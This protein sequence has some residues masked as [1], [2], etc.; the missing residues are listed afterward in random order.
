MHL[1]GTHF[2]RI[3][4]PIWFYK[5]NMMSNM[6]YWESHLCWLFVC[7]GT[8]GCMWFRKQ[9]VFHSLKIPHLF[10][11]FPCR[12]SIQFSSDEA[13]ACRL[14]TNE[15][16]FYDARD[17]SKGILRRLR[18]PGVAG[19]EISKFPGSHVAAFT[20][21]SKVCNSI[22]SDWVSLVFCMNVDR[23]IYIYTNACC[24]TMSY[25]LASF[26]PPYLNSI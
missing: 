5:R 10:L 16:Q 21:E 11:S 15:I 3:N 19:I 9:C 4:F 25:K 26:F 23:R 6:E 20:P 8:G 7:I 13:V 12:P 18:I 2:P 22:V 1:R 14:A 24:N 17:F